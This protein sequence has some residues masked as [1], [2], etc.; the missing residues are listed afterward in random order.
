[1]E[2]RKRSI[3]LNNK[4]VKKDF[5]TFSFIRQENIQEILYGNCPFYEQENYLQKTKD[6]FVNDKPIFS[7]IYVS[8]KKRLRYQ[9]ALRTATAV[10]MIPV[11]CHAFHV[12]AARNVFLPASCPDKKRKELIKERKENIQLGGEWKYK[13]ISVLVNGYKVDG[14][15][16]GKP[17]TLKNRKWLIFVAGNNSRYESILYNDQSPIKAVL[18]KIGFNALVFSYPGVG[19]SEGSPTQRAMINAYC[20]MLKFLTDKEKGIG[21]DQIIS[22]GYST[23]GCI[24][25]EGFSLSTPDQVKL[26]IKDRSP[27]TLARA[28]KERMGY[29]FETIAKAFGW[30]ASSMPKENS[31]LPEI[32]IQT[33]ES[34]TL[35]ALLDSSDQIAKDDGKVLRNA[36]LAAAIFSANR[37]NI[38]VLGVSEKHSEDLSSNSVDLLVSNIKEILG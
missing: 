25:N 38:K 11:V 36:S 26:V 18:T 9:E 2:F 19:S 33:A 14:A 12:M 6:D 13:K 20:S 31:S 3:L 24:E 37:K 8:N 30:S 5:M 35:P 4:I 28:A 10:T 16:F 34:S 22:Y 7:P 17:E 32:V 1:M 27:V 15:I 29:G 23:G 21:A